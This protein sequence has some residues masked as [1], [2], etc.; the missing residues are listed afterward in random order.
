MSPLATY[1]HLFSLTGPAYVVVAFLGRLPLA[2]SQLGTLLFVAG[3]TGSYAAGGASAGALA[4]AN[5]VSAPAAGVL[6]DR[7]GQ[8]RVVLVQALGGALGL[9]ALLSSSAAGARWEAQAACAALAGLLIPQVGPLARVRWRPITATRVRGDHHHR[10]L[11]DAAFSYEGAADEASFV[12]GPAM[13]GVAVT[14]LSPGAALVSAAVLLAVFGSLFALHPTAQAAHHGAARS[15][16]S[17]ALLSGALL[18]L[19]LAQFV[20]G[21][22]FGSVQ[23]GTSALATSEGV[24]GATGLLHGLLGVG[25]VLAGLAVTALPSRFRFERRL[26]LFASGLLVLSLPLLLVH[27]LGELAA[28]LAVL[29][30]AVAPYMITVFTLAERITPTRRTSAAMTLLAGVTGLGYAVG[31]SVAGRLADWNGYHPAFAVTVTAG[32]LAVLVAAPAVRSLA[33]AQARAAVVPD[34]PQQPVAELGVGG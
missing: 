18:L 12:L 5:A 34:Q 31:S 27:G 24:P 30:I 1:R 28:T 22:V 16:P 19:C 6:A 21:M 8:R 15:G 23:T 32:G 2:M 9:L 25:S 4:V 14:L 33:R 10:T 13:V 17:S 20:I 11:I 26:V 29:G 7:H 3:S